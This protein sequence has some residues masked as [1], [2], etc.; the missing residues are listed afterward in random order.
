V[1]Y[2]TEQRMVIFKFAERFLSHEFLG[3]VAVWIMFL[4]ACA[5]IATLFH[6]LKLCRQ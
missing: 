2:S 6:F 1:Y 4:L 5:N 3:S